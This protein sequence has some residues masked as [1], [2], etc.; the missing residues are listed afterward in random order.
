M[1]TQC[2]NARVKRE[3]ILQVVVDA[4]NRLF[5]IPAETAFD[6]IYRTASGVNWDEHRRA[7]LGAIPRE[8]NLARWFEQIVSMAAIEYGIALEVTPAT[9]WNGVDA[10]SMHQIKTFSQSDWLEKLLSEQKQ[11]SDAAYD[12]LL[13]RQVLAEAADHWMHGN[14]AEYSRILDPHRGRLTPAQLKRLAIAER[15][16]QAER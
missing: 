3:T 10:T 14:F 9:E 13:M 5:I 6:H 1:D 11:Q 8:W 4:N 16:I 7:L 12:G 15:R 2:D